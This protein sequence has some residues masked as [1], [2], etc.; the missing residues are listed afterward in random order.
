[1]CKKPLQLDDRTVK[2]GHCIEC[3][4]ERS[5]EWAFRLESESKSWNQGAFIT[6]TYNDEEAIWIDG[7]DGEMITTI[8][9]REF[10]LFMKRLRKESKKYSNL[11]LRYFACGEYGET[12]GRAHYHAIIF[13]IPKEAKKCLDKIWK[14]GFVKVGDVTPKSIRYV[15]NYMLLKDINCLPGQEKPFVLMSRNPGLGQKYIQ[16][17]KP[18]HHVTGSPWLQVPEKDFKRKMPK[19]YVDKCIPEEMQEQSKIDRQLHYQEFIDKQE[20]EAREK[21]PEDPGQYIRDVKEHKERMRI[22]NRKKGKL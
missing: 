2:C 10:Q 7:P 16:S 12:F 13:N 3:L 20:A 22:K 6:L 1:M 8:E 18:F 19:Y 21:N 15:T 4:I 5:Q 14:K 9:K 17:N 11:P